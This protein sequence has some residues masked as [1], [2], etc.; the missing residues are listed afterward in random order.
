MSGNTIV[1]Q[2]LSKGTGEGHIW[3]YNLLTGENFQLTPDST[4]Q[5]RAFVSGR[6]V[7]YTDS[8]SGKNQIYVYDLVTRQ[9]FQ[10]SDGLFDSRYPSVDGNRAV[11]MEDI[12]GNWQIF[13]ADLSSNSAPAPVAAPEPSGWIL[14]VS[15]LLGLVVLSRARKIKSPVRI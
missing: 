10:L 12:A 11:W 14:L 7:V 2:K 6:W 3:A 4:T 5:S 8:R 15:G 13:E 9:E 1:Y